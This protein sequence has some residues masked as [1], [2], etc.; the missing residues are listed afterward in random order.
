MTFRYRGPVR[1]LCRYCGKPIAKRTTKVYIV[2]ELDPR[3]HKS[4]EFIRYIAS[5]ERVRD[6][7][8]C[9][10]LTNNEV[11]AVSY[12]QKMENGEPCGERYI[13]SFSEWD[14]ESYDDEFFC[15]GDDAKRFGYFAV[16][17][18]NV[19]TNSYVKAKKTQRS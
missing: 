18:G 15:S 9:K 4:G 12:W 14:G 8:G 5:P 11:T 17:N 6:K 16:I 19:Q 2:E 1:P 7:A 13:T 3:F 10:R